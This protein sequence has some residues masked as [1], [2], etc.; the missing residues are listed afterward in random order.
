V[1]YAE[2]VMMFVSLLARLNTCRLATRDSCFN[3]G[4]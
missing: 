2:R 1:L 4:C 3:F